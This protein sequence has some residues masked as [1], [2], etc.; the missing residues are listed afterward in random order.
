MNI[1]M[2][3]DYAADQLV[4]PNV[5][6]AIGQSLVMTPL[7]ALA[8]GGIE[9]ENAGS[10]SALFNMMRNLGGS[11]GIALLS[12]FTTIR[13]QFHFQII[14]TNV[15]MNSLMAQERIGHLAQTLCCFLRDDL[16][17]S[18]AGRSHLECLEA[19]LCNM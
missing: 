7:S 6:R 16:T 3:H 18:I 12:T 2:S 8:T 14:A 17:A 13:E 19:N 5:I 1:Y 11:I 9:R 10:A 4:L 15:T